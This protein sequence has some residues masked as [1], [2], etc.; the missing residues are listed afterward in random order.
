[1]QEGNGGE[2][3][4]GEGGKEEESEGVHGQG[5]FVRKKAFGPMG[6]RFW[7]WGQEVR[8]EGVPEGSGREV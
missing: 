6:R 7:S 1:M 8:A 3:G 2:N 4:Q 5:S